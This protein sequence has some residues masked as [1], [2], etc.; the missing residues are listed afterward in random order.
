MPPLLN[1][2]RYIG[3][4]ILCLVAVRHAASVSAPNKEEIPH[5]TAEAGTAEARLAFSNGQRVAAAVDLTGQAHAMPE[6]KDS[7]RA[8]I[9]TTVVS[10]DENVDCLWDT[11]VDWSVCQFSCGGG[12]SVRTR[13]VKIMATG[14]GAACDTNDRETRV[15]NKNPCPLDCMW[16]EWSPWGV[17]SVTCGL[18]TKTKTRE[19]K[20]YQQYGGA[21]CVGHWSLAT[22]CEER[23]CAVD[24]KW[25]DWGDWE[26]CS[27][28]C[29]TGASSRYRTYA[30]VKNAFGEDCTGENFQTEKCGMNSCPVD[31]VMEDWGAW[32]PC[33]VT[34]GTGATR[35]SRK[36]LTHPTYGGETCGP[37]TEEGT[38]HNGLCPV[39][40]EVSDWSQWSDCSLTC[41]SENS[42]GVSKRTRKVVQDNNALGNACDGDLEQTIGCSRMQCPVDCKLSEWSQWSECSTSCGPGISERERSMST[43]A[44][45]GGRDCAEESYQKKYCT[46]DICPV[47]CQW[48]D[49]QDWRGCSTTCANGT[50]Y[51]MRLVQTPMLHGGRE[52][53]GGS[54]QN[55]ACNAA[56]CPIHCQ[57]DEWTQWSQCSTTC[58]DGSLSRSR[59][60][61]VHPLYGGNACNGTSTDTTSCDQAGCPVQCQW[62]EWSAYG[63]CT[64]SCGT[65]QHSRTREKTVLAQNGGAD[66]TGD[67]KET[68]ACPDL[69]ACPVDCEWDDWSQWESCSTTC[70]KGSMKRSRIRK[71]YEKD[72]GH[73]CYG[74]E[75]DEKVC[76]SDPCPVDCLLG[77]WTKWSECSSS[78]GGGVELRTRQIL[79]VAAHGGVACNTSDLL[80]STA[81]EEVPCPIH[82]VWGHWSEWSTCTKECEG[83]VTYRHRSEVI[84]AEYGG[85]QCEGSADEEMV[86]NAHGC[87]VDCKFG[88]WSEWSDCSKSCDSGNRTAGR[89]LITAPQWGGQPCDGGIMKSEYCNEQPCPED[90]T[91]GDWSHY[92]VCSKTCG[93]GEMLRTRPRIGQMYGGSPCDGNDTDST[94]CNT[95]GCPQDCEWGPW[96]AWT[97]CSKECGG[98]SIKRFREV[99]VEKDFGG[100]PCFGSNAQE[101][102]CNF[103]VCTINCEW[104]DWELWSPCSK[105]CNGGTRTK[106]RNKKWE[107]SNGG[108]PCLG[109]ATDMEKCNTDPC[110]VDCTFELWESWGECSTSCGMGSRF[111]TRVKKEE[112]YGGAPCQDVMWEVGECNNPESPNCP[113]PT[114]STTTSLAVLQLP[115]G[116][117]AWSHLHNVWEPQASRGPLAVPSH[118]VLSKTFTE[119]KD[120]SYK[121]KAYKPCKAGELNKT[122]EAFESM[123]KQGGDLNASEAD[124]VKVIDELISNM[125]GAAPD[126]Q[127]LGLDA[128][129]A[130]KAFD[131]NNLTVVAK[132]QPDT[133]SSKDFADA[134]EASANKLKDG[135]DVVA[136]VAGDLG[137]DVIEADEFVANKN[138]TV[139]ME[140][141]IAVLAGAKA[142][143]VKVDITIPQGMLLST[144][145][146]KVKGNVNVAYMVEVYKQDENKGN[147]SLLAS[148][149]S[150]SDIDTVTTEVRDQV[151][152]Q[153]L[154]FTLRAVSLSVTVLPVTTD[155]NIDVLG[156]SVDALTNASIEDAVPTAV[157]DGK[158][159]ATTEGAMVETAQKQAKLHSPVSKEQRRKLETLPSSIEEQGAEGAKSAARHLAIGSIGASAL[160]SLF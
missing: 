25:S 127:N 135:K 4:S 142:S 146:R 29:G 130:A 148:R 151:L 9:T 74:Y 40:C 80:Q 115:E 122:L 18:G 106:L 24:C 42:I 53:A 1:S 95:R 107:S 154:T 78:C 8:T 41:S 69:P 104:N 19:K 46:S 136:E 52:C 51:R 10:S 158:A 57:W 100:D 58:G 56:F 147:A 121:G 28:S 99:I 85:K 50:S 138:V 90:C 61:K 120:P 20:Q 98:G 87:P 44:Q 159:K 3:A 17:C 86:C 81:C 15:C 13:K 141:A 153:G 112:L 101:A 60:I 16:D 71:V 30:Q 105:S 43:P 6:F 11:W 7:G 149:I 88:D 111:R 96:S 5:A 109:N 113:K 12:E 143:D 155:G 75:D 89:P 47:D 63:S 140:K 67:G 97:G 132:S 66:C 145:Q 62:S 33:D 36:V 152:G 70:G 59:E 129:Q 128:A 34:C 64:S 26:G 103:D 65:G 114:T 110:P 108:L 93:G 23:V 38:C 72:G 139:A 35:R 91:W 125:S 94:P 68:E 84:V 54:Q 126:A 48:A 27:K 137:L 133:D 131:I 92:S 39:H 82:C 144:W 31:C 14:N 49:W 2:R 156:A 37:T 150:S 79:V 116:Q 124:A 21:T 83:G 55:R 117:L 32:E 45:Y 119:S 73:T 22:D 76:E 157:T 77:S 134:F 118:E 160:W 123:K 102:G